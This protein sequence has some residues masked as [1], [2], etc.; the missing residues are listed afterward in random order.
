MVSLDTTEKSGVREAWLC[1]HFTFHFRYLYTIIRLYPP[2]HPPKFSVLQDKN[3]QLSQSFLR[4][5]MF[6]TPNHLC[7]TLHMWT[8]S[9]ISLYLLYQG[10]PE[11]DPALPIYGITSAE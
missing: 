8:L 10:S 11:L 4:G 6:Y 5:D 2:P 7:G 3:S 9:I 1:H